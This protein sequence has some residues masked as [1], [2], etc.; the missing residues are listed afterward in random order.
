MPQ[1]AAL[2]SMTERM[3]CGRLGRAIG[4]RWISLKRTARSRRS[5]LPAGAIS[6]MSSII[7]SVAEMFSK[8]RWS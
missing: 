4:R 1:R 2:C 6:M 5:G 3:T 7:T 8:A